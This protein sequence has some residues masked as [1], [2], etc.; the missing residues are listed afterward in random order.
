MK[1]LVTVLV[2]VA[3][4]GTACGRAKTTLNSASSPTNSTASDPTLPPGWTVENQK[5][6]VMSK[7]AHYAP[8]PANAH[9]AVSAEQ[10]WHAYLAQSSDPQAS[11]PKVAVTASLGTYTQDGADASRQ[12]NQPLSAR[13]RLVWILHWQNFF[14]SQEVPHGKPTPPGVSAPSTTNDPGATLQSTVLVDAMSGAVILMDLAAPPVDD[15]NP[16]D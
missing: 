1:R 7:G 3:M 4:L 6:P 8:P 10:A 13:H 15:P 11:T 2:L 12:G 16:P 9:A 5:K 14:T